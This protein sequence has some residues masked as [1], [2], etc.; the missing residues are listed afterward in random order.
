MRAR[1]AGTSTPEA[2]SMARAVSVC[3]REASG[4]NSGMNVGGGLAD[5]R[6]RSGRE[7]RGDEEEEEETKKRSTLSRVSFSESLS[8]LSLGEEEETKKRRK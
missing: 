5:H 6:R 4:R 8:H 2:A 1:R 3:G 7:R